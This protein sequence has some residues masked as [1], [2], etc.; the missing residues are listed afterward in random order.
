MELGLSRKTVIITGGASNIGYGITLAFAKEG[1]NVVIS[2]I[3]DLQSQK[4]AQL[5]TQM[6]VRA[7]A[8]QTDVT[9][10]EQC[11]AMVKKTL[12]EFGHLDILVNN[13]G[14]GAGAIRYFKDFTREDALKVLDLNFMGVFNSTKAVLD[15]MKANKSGVI[16]NIASVVALRSHPWG[17]IYGTAKAAVLAHSKSLSLEVAEYGIRVNVVCPGRT[18]PTRIEQ[19]GEKSVHYNVEHPDILKTDLGANTGIEIPGSVRDT[20]KI[21]VIWSSFWHPRQQAT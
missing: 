20:L 5:A 8:I 2:D 7:L 18:V 12:H 19:L 9:L 16:I 1:A 6:G 17:A 13:A 11:E 21:S 10:P 15:S 4:V 3:D 14:G